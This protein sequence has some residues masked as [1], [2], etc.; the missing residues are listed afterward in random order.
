[1]EKRSIL[2]WRFASFPTEVALAFL[3]SRARPIQADRQHRYRAAQNAR[4]FG[5]SFGRSW[6]YVFDLR[7]YVFLRGTRRSF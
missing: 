4:Q 1:M 2:S 7:F 3:F 6:E 5:L